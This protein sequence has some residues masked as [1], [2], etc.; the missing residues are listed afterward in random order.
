MTWSLVWEAFTAVGTVA[1]AVTTVA[2]IRQKQAATPG[3]PSANLGSR[4]V[5]G[6]DAFGRRD[7][8]QLTRSP[9]SDKVF[10]NCLRS[11]E[12]GGGPAVQLRLRLKFWVNTVVP[13][14]AELSPLGT[15]GSFA[16]P[17]R[18]PIFLGTNTAKLNTS[19]RPNEV[20]FGRGW[21]SIADCR[22]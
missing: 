5:N 2:V 12:H 19:G 11:E 21:D 7:L 3:R 1:V 22:S 9:R 6:A 13:P 18:I 10:H 15:H 16:R 4:A 20:S 14:E 17:L 8:L